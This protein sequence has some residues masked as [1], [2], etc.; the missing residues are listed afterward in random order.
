MIELRKSLEAEIPR[1][2]EMERSD[3]A[4]KFIIPHTL[5][6]HLS[7]I[8]KEDV[9]YLS[10]YKD[11]MLQGFFIL[12]CGTSQDVEFRRVVVSSKGGGIGQE[13]I[14]LMEEYCKDNLGARRIWLDVFAFNERGQHIYKKLGYQQFGTKVHEGKQLLL[15][16]KQLY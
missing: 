11:N 15:F 8:N 5:E 14:K 9:L 2:I 13:S 4:S 6:K 10:I 1:F 12:S 7:E 3:E 16:E